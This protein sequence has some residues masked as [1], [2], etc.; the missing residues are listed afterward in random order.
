MKFP[1]PRNPKSILLPFTLLA[2]LIMSSEFSTAA[3]SKSQDFSF[4]KDVVFNAIMR[5]VAADYRLEG[6]D[7]ETGIVSFQTGGQLWSFKA[8]KLDATVT[9]I[10]QDRSEVEVT[11]RKGSGMIFGWGR[12]DNQAEGFLK[13]LVA[14]LERPPSSPTEFL[15]TS[16]S[17]PEQSADQ[18][19]SGNGGCAVEI[20][21]TPVGADIEIDGAFTGNTPSILNLTCGDHNLALKLRGHLT[22]NR[23]FRLVPGNINISGILEEETQ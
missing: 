18:T 21:S 9:S 13:K 15:N 20:T 2:L 6:N 23:T 14:E 7:R 4:G 17:L 19:N 1:K 10:S 22:W 11:V 8:F 12:G 5:V 3:T 16:D